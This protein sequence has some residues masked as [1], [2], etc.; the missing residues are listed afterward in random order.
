MSPLSWGPF[1]SSQTVGHLRC[2]RT[3]PFL[4]PVQTE[5]QKCA[6]LSRPTSHI[7]STPPLSQLKPPSDPS[8][9]PQAPHVSAGLW[10]SP[11]RAAS[12]LSSSH[13]TLLCSQEKGVYIVCV[14]L[15]LGLLCA[16]SWSKPGHLDLFSPPTSCIMATPTCSPPAAC[17]VFI[18]LCLCFLFLEEPRS[19]LL[20]SKWLI[21][22]CPLA[23]A[24]APAV[25]CLFNVG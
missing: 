8:S 16:H 3:D 21:L 1:R 17:S 15:R 14:V 2:S 11:S 23:E 6:A 24:S 25:C 12:T 20:S 7:R 18:L 9:P 5:E 22:T 13:S 10:Q 19:P 4:L